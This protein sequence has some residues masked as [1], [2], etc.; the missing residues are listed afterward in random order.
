MPVLN[1]LLHW[2]LPNPCLWC[3]FSVQQ[4]SAQLCR[5]CQAALPTLHPPGDVPLLALPAIARSF[6]RRLFDEL[7]AVSWYQRPWS[8]W[9]LDWKYQQNMA[10]GAALQTELARAA[11][12]WP[13]Q[14]D[15]VCY[16]PVSRS[17]LRQRGFNQAQQLAAVLSRHYQLPLLDIFAASPGVPHQLGATAAQRR[18]QL[19]H[20][21]SLQPGQQPLPAALL[22]VDDVITTGAT[23][24]QLCRLLRKAGVQRISVCT[25]L[26]TPAPDVDITLYSSESSPPSAELN[27]LPKY[28]ALT[29]NRPEPTK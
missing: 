3:R 6:R 13:V 2:C 21:F 28:S 12:R 9:L 15:A 10:A 14:A 8:D 7:W 4:P 27:A 5:Q 25:L 22:L 11:V 24:H 26:I 20:K 18:R 19:R 1:Q 16:T 17:R 23:L 29:N